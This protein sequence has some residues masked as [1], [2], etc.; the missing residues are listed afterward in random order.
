M[1]KS[2]DDCDA[3][4]LV[5]RSKSSACTRAASLDAFGG[6][7]GG[8][9]RARGLLVD[10]VAGPELDLADAVS[11]RPSAVEA[12]REWIDSM[13]RYPVRRTLSVLTSEPF[14]LRFS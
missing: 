11:T 4:S 3:D 1:L 14:E 10:T 2:G 9:S 8:G 5:E 7:P 13:A 12:G 6:R